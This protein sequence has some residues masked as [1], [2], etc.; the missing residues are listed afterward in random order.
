VGDVDFN[1]QDHFVLRIRENHVGAAHKV[2]LSRLGHKLFLLA[3]EIQPAGFVLVHCALVIHVYSLHGA[4]FPNRTYRAYVPL[5]AARQHRR[6]PYPFLLLQNGFGLSMGIGFVLVVAMFSRRPYL[7]FV[8]KV[9]SLIYIA[10]TQ[11]HRSAA[12]ATAIGGAQFVRL[13]SSHHVEL[14]IM[15]K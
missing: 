6:N 7:H 4:Y 14:L 3:L 8:A 2:P 1:E 15:S 12:A 9:P 11:P 5:G 13:I 10:V